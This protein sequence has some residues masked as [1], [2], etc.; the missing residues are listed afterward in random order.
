MYQDCSTVVE[1]ARLLKETPWLEWARAI[2]DLVKGVAWPATLLAAALLFRDQI[3]EKIRDLRKAGPTGAEFDPAQSHAP[4]TEP[5]TEITTISP[6]T[7]TPTGGGETIVHSFSTITTVGNQLLQQVEGLPLEQR[8]TVLVSRLAEARVISQFE[9]IWGLIF[10]SQITFLRRL[11]VVPMVRSEAMAF[12][13]EN[14]R[15]KFT[16]LAE[17]DFDKWAKFLFNQAL[18]EE[19]GSNIAITG[20][21]RDFITW[22][23]LAKATLGRSF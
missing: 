9:F 11:S 17:W 8:V 13:E 12:Y 6:T 4:A 16:E 3:R 7:V 5:S 10:Q 19:A 21:G 23:D 1:I 14:A 22:V 20:P 15:S 2:F 18:I